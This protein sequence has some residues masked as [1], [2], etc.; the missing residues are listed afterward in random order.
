MTHC[1]FSSE[2]Y[3]RTHIDDLY[4]IFIFF[5]A[6]C[7]RFIYEYMDMDVDMVETRQDIQNR[8]DYVNDNDVIL[9]NSAPIDSKKF[10]QEAKHCTGNNGCYF[11]FLTRLTL[12]YAQRV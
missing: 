6:F 2:C 3:T 9:E 10:E 12:P 5:V 4:F 11:A 8:K 1:F 7:Q